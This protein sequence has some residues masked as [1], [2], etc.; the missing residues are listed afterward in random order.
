MST[1]YVQEK[2][3]ICLPFW[4][5]PVGFQKACAI[6]VLTDGRNGHQLVVRPD[7]VTPWV[8]K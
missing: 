3:R 7:I 4:L 5:D 6:I 2:V 8:K 1:Y